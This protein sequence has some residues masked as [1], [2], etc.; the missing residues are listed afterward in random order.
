MLKRKTIAAISVAALAATTVAL[1]AAVANADTPVQLAACN[2]CA[3]KKCGAAKA[4]C[5]GKSPCN[6]CGATKAKCGAKSPCNPCAGKK[7]K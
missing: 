3:G 5:G 2:P 7:K 1:P 6:P 4:K